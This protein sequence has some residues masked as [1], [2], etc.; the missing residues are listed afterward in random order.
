[1][2]SRPGHFRGIVVLDLFGGLDVFFDS[3]RANFEAADAKLRP[4]YKARNLGIC[5]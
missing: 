5:K 4:Q 1:M 3:D 2:N